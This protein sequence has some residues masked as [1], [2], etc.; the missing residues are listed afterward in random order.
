MFQVTENLIHE[1]TEPCLG[2]AWS[3]NVTCRFCITRYNSSGRRDFEVIF[4]PDLPNNKCNFT[5]NEDGL[6]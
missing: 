3:N 1:K 5:V 4:A 2:L 6:V